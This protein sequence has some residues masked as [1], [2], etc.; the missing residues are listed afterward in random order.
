MSLASGEGVTF[1][2][3]V[4]MAD[5]SKYWLSD[6]ICQ[7]RLGAKDGVSSGEMDAF[8]WAIELVNGELFCWSVP[9]LCEHRSEEK[10]SIITCSVSFYFASTLSD[11]YLFRNFPGDPKKLVAAPERSQESQTK[12]TCST[13]IGVQAEFKKYASWVNAWCRL[14]YWKRI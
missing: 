12:G 8:V 4:D 13:I 3:V 1:A 11:L 14:P 5:T 9:F 7:S 6:V 2:P 10:V